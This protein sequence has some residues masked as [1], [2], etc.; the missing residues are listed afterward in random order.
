MLIFGTNQQFA[1]DT[2]YGSLS[3][4]SGNASFGSVNHWLTNTHFGVRIT[5]LLARQGIRLADQIDSATISGAKLVS[6]YVIEHSGEVASN[7]TIFVFHFGIALI[8]LFYF[9]RD[10][11]SYYVALLKLMPLHED[12]KTAIFETLSL[13]LSSVMRGL[14]LTALLDGVS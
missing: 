10:G 13:T 3:A 14:M 2:M 6:G 9:L 1:T 12:D 7:L 5:A 11:E 4:L 8:T